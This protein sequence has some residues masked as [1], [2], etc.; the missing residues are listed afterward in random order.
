MR[1]CVSSPLGG[2]GR[3]ACIGGMELSVWG[4]RAR[5]DSAPIVGFPLHGKVPE[6]VLAGNLQKDALATIEAFSGHI[7]Q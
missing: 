4:W 1:F 5:A 3:R 6:K 2:P 7:Y